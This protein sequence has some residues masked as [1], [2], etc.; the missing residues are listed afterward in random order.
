[1]RM[2]IE[3][4]CVAK[5]FGMNYSFQVETYGI[6][7]TSSGTFHKKNHVSQLLNFPRQM[8]KPIEKISNLKKPIQISRK[9]F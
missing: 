3:K 8:K 7:I 1:M 2:V 6:E 9:N 5:M 4:N